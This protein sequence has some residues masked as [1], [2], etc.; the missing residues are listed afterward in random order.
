MFA[1]IPHPT[2]ALIL[3]RAQKAMLS[4]LNAETEK[5]YWIPLF[6]L[7]AFFNNFD[8]SAIR[9]CKQAAM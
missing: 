9:P 2:E 6:P 4:H 1:V 8:Y 5:P 7:W 3:S